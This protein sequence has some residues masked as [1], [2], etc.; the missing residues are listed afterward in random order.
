[1]FGV[2]VAVRDRLK[3]DIGH[4]GRKESYF[5]AT[6]FIIKTGMKHI[7]HMID[8]FGFVLKED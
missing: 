2:V 1:M 4:L 8:E 6:K 3:K 7:T 5:L